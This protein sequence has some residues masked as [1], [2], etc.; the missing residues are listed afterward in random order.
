MRAILIASFLFLCT[1]LSLTA[2]N[3]AEQMKK[4]VLEQEFVQALKF[5]GT[6]LRENPKS[7]EILLLAGDV[8]SEMDK[9]DSAIIA[10]KM[11]AELDAEN[12]N[13]L[14]KM[15]L[16]QANAGKLQDA[17]TTIRKAL[18]KK[19][20]DVDN[21]ITQSAIYL[22]A[23]S[24]VQAE[25]TLLKA[26]EI[27]S[28]RPEVFIG[29]GDYYYAKKIYELAKN[30]F[31]EALQL[32]SS[33]LGARIKLASSYYRLANMES[34]QTL[35]NELFARSLKEWNAITKA[36]PKNA[37]AFYEQGKIFF[38]AS[39]FPEAGV[40]FNRYAVLRPEGWLG[41]WYAAQSWYKARRYDSAVVHLEAVRTQ[42]DT[43]REKA[44]AMLAHTYFE[45]KKFK[46]SV[47]LYKAMGKL[48]QTNSERFGYAAFFSGDTTT[49]IAAFYAAIDGTEKKCNTMFRF[50]NLLFT[51]KKYDDAITVFRKRIAA[52]DDSNSVKAKYFVGLS[53]FS[54]NRPDSAILAIQD[55]LKSETNSV[56]GRVYIANSF[57]SLKKA[58]SAKKYLNE[59]LE[60]S[61]TALAANPANATVKK[62]TEQAYDALCR[63]ALEN[64]E[65][66]QVIKYGKS[67]L[68]INP[69]S[70][71]AYLYLGFAYQSMN[72][73]DNACKA[74]GDVLKRDPN[75][76]AAAKNKK[77]LGC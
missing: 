65:F 44:D 23:D 38:L 77:A 16:A 21:L 62:E 1:Q 37:T 52:C 6:A 25:Y 28:K 49:A 15:A 11:A 55:Y 51:M 4:A 74:Y 69:E 66:A 39:K 60:I 48:D 30:N 3:A 34:D 14:R 70:T 72:E 45:I 50:G 59:A 54:A 75:N 22:K 68:E 47:A 63:M 10:Y 12:L 61:K 20:K 2:Q 18:K 5:A 76:Q 29:L 43:I 41:R 71:T 40:S 67:W 27:D 42:I 13:S 24:L 7:S 53:H 31:E 9:F 46:E 8:Y 17:M 57:T 32:N 19:E 58:D 56:S 26:R 36:D 73:K 33:L 35:S 64:K